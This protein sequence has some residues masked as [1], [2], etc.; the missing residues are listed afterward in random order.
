MTFY[1]QLDEIYALG[2]YRPSRLLAPSPAGP[3]RT[4]QAVAQV[5]A[6]DQLRLDTTIAQ[7]IQLYDE[8]VDF[9][10]L[11]AS[12]DSDSAHAL[13]EVDTDSAHALTEVDTDSAHALRGLGAPRWPL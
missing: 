4:C 7:L 5:L 12:V 11:S 8:V 10:Q 6:A 9:A 13:T 2:Q 3:P 1:A